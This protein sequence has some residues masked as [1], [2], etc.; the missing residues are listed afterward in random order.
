M[1]NK[2]HAENVDKCDEKLLLS[3]VSKRSTPNNGHQMLINILGNN[4]VQ[5]TITKEMIDK[6]KYEI[7][8][9]NSW[10]DVENGC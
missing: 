7:R 4:Y 5:N 3:D 8:N 2:K 10:K 9:P 1:K 6:I